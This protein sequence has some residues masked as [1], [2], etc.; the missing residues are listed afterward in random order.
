[1][2]VGVKAFASY[3]P[4]SV[5]AEINAE[6]DSNAASVKIL[7]ANVQKNCNYDVC[8]NSFS[9]SFCEGINNFE[10]TNW[11][12]KLGDTLLYEGK[13]PAQVDTSIVLNAQNSLVVS[14]D[15][16]DFNT[17]KSLINQH[18]V[19]FSFEVDQVNF[20]QEFDLDMPLR[21][22]NY[23]TGYYN[24]GRDIAINYSAD[25]DNSTKNKCKSV[26][27]SKALSYSE[28]SEGTAKLLVGTNA[29]WN[30]SFEFFQNKNNVNENVLAQTDGYQISVDENTIAILGDSSSACFYALTTLGDIFNCVDGVK[31][32]CVEASDYA[33]VADRGVIE[34]FYGTPFSWDARIDMTSYMGQFKMNKYVYAPKDDPY[35]NAQWREPYPQSG[36]YT[37][38]EMA[39]LQNN[40]EANHINLN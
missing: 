25:I 36:A 12:I 31:L 27:D 1:M 2:F 33:N 16:L 40:C 7:P 21:N 35:H 28:T 10:N 4:I 37:I 5:D 20:T 17:A 15:S 9:A 39:R 14:A 34:G 26:L 32:R 23:G 13:F 19:N 11:N 6:V 38:S 29:T 18:I 8:V 30:A 3:N 24:L 22:L